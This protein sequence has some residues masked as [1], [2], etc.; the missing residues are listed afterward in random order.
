MKVTLIK[1]STCGMRRQNAHC[2]YFPEMTFSKIRFTKLV[3]FVPSC[4]TVWGGERILHL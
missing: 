1:E 2:T 4:N 3:F